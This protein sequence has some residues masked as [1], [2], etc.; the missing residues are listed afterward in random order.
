MQL[1]FFLSVGLWGIGVEA[2]FYGHYLG[3]YMMQVFYLYFLLNG[4]S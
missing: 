3:F 1:M 2:A 4:Y